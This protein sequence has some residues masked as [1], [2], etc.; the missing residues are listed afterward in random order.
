MRVK[1][2]QLTR[3]NLRIKSTSA[4]T[5]VSMVKKVLVA[6]DNAFIRRALGSLLSQEL[7]V[8]V[9]EAQ[10]GKEAIEKAGELQPD[11]IVLDL[12]MPV[13]NGLEAARVIKNVLPAVPL[14]LYSA[15]VN[16]FAKKE[17]HSIG[18]SELVS[19]SEHTSVLIR[20]ARCLLY[21]TAA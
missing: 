19:K 7:E 9:C 18:I 6:D 2:G 8:E 14:I 4:R 5:F 13:M 17:A 20:K 21:P 1:A 11:L 10:N 3:N 12:S 15:F 16:E